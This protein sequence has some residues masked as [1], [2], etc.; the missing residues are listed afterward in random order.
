[1]AVQLVALFML[2]YNTTAKMPQSLNLA[3]A[4]ADHTADSMMEQA[5]ELTDSPVMAGD[6][7]DAEGEET[8]LLEQPNIS[9]KRR[10]QDAKFNS[11]YARALQWA[12]ICR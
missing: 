11:W 9:D 12:C 4:E 5:Q 6:E 3:Q 7:S 1:M 2:I 8:L 10:Q